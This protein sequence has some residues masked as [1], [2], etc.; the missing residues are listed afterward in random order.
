MSVTLTE[1]RPEEVEIGTALGD[2]LVTKVVVDHAYESVTL[3]LTGR[4]AAITLPIDTRLIL[5]QGDG[6]W[7]KLIRDWPTDPPRMVDKDFDKR[8]ETYRK[9]EAEERKWSVAAAQEAAQ[10]GR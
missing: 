2:R 3:E 10:K 1:V 9:K 6:P 4:G 7:D 8:M 5:V